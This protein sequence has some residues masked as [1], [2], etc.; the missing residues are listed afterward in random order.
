MSLFRT[1]DRTS[2]V[3]HTVHP[4]PFLAFLY[5]L[6]PSQTPIRPFGKSAVKQ[7]PRLPWAGRE[8]IE[9]ALIQALGRAG[10]CP[11]HAKQL[12][13]QHRT[14]PRAAAHHRPRRKPAHGNEWRAFSSSRTEQAGQ[15]GQ[16]KKQGAFSKI[17]QFAANE[18]QA[19][20]EYY[21]IDLSEQPE[22]DDDLVDDGPLV[23]NVGDD[24]QPWPSN[25]P[26]VHSA[27]ATIEKLLEDEESSHA[28]LYDTYK[29][30]PSPGVVYL[31][32]QTIRALL[33]HLS[34]LERPTS[35]A[36]HR[37]LAILEDMK[38]A[39]IHITLSEWTTAIHL[40]GHH[41]GKVS[42]HDV[43]AALQVW[44]DMERRANINAS[45]VTM[46]VLFHVAVRAGKYML[47]ERFL[48]EMRARKLK[49]HRH[50]RIS[51]IYYYGVL[52]NSQAIRKVYYEMIAAGDI[53]DTVALN[54]VMAALIRAGEPAAAE[55]VFGRMKKLHAAKTNIFVPRK[56]FDAR[57]WRSRRELG[58]I[59]TK[60]GQEFTASGDDEKRKELQELAPI[61]PNS[62]TYSILIRHQ[63]VVVGDMDRVF[64]LLREM[65]YEG[66][67]MEGSIFVFMF[68][69]FCNFGG[70][71]Y[72]PWTSR[73]LEQTWTEY[74]HAVDQGLDRTWFS[75]LAVSTAL[76]AFKKCTNGERALRAW[77]E[78]RKVWEPT[79]ADEQAILRLLGQLVPRRDAFPSQM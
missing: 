69:G 34:V 24:H 17:K 11:E 40:V 49:L 45:T 36:M 22:D 78:V 77:E 66:V 20:V 65:G 50:F 2:A 12:S 62:R 47:A 74:L 13:T 8:C 79:H 15:T 71:R 10:S 72:S 32:A 28:L 76:R 39:H 67:P 51:L 54:A 58:I 1:L 29:L 44:R 73:R 60:R 63:A 37:F 68:Y 26:Q 3:S 55:H 75:K 42:A 61:A 27:T 21:K 14:V 30:M 64:E 41:L 43:H 70:V 4:R 18:L 56:P 31:R 7:V 38:K 19:L 48:K 33:H 35:M 57:T 25:D 53:I 5:P 16:T 23:W 46:N 52:G 59:L 9:T 6:S